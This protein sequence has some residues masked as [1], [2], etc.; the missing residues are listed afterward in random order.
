MPDISISPET[1]RGILVVFLY[2]LAVLAA[3]SIFNLAGAFGEILDQGLTG[4]FGW[5]RV[6]LPIVLAVFATKIL[7]PEKIQLRT[8]GSLGL[9]LLVLVSNGIIEIFTLQISP[10]DSPWYQGGG[11]LGLFFAAP[12]FSVMGF[13]AGTVVLLA[14]AVVALLLTFNT[15][16]HKIAGTTSIFAAPLRWFFNL[17]GSGGRAEPK[18][19]GLEAE[20]APGA[21]AEESFTSRAIEISVPKVDEALPTPVSA[22]P[23]TLVKRPRQR[24]EVPLDLL[25]LRSGKPAAGDI[26]ANIEKIRRTLERFGIPVEMSD[27]SVGPTVTQYTLRP[28]EGIKLS[29]IT[30]LSNDLALSLAAHPIRIEAPIPGKSLVGIEVPNSTVSLVPLREV[31]ESPEFKNRKNALEIALGKDV[32]GR[33]WTANIGK[34]PHLLVAGATGSGKSV[35]L[36]TIIVSLLYQNGPDDLRFIMV[37]PKRVELQVYNGVPHLITPVITDIAK[38]VNA[39][40]WTIGE[41][42]RRFDLLSKAGFRDIGS[43][44]AGSPEKLPYIVIVIDE[45]ADLMVAA[46]AEVES[47][48]I[49]L[50]QMARA[51]GIHLVLA[52]QRPSVDVI[53]GLIKANITTRIAFAVASGTDSRTILDSLGAEKL[54]GRGDLL[55]TTADLSKPKRLQGCLVTDEEIRKVVDHVKGTGGPPN[56]INEVTERAK[57]GP[58]SSTV[59]SQ[60]DSDPLLGEAEDTVLRAGKASASLLQRRLK[61]GYARAARLLDLLEEK[62]VI[63]PGD[64]AKP[65]EI[66]VSREGLD[67]LSGAGQGDEEEYDEREES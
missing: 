18:I 60:D 38:T 50:A 57:N 58:G 12:L 6:V 40:K 19:I 39:L 67:N 1:R 24:I 7:A 47:S 62:G 25:T 61:V 35:C 45:L 49:R 42:E 14:L 5:D 26:Q 65:R 43:Y 11:F 51:V 30:A 10:M 53:T 37:D 33:A 52:T 32:S 44:N 66:L 56:Y 59:F 17:F 2:A 22:E 27:V 20:E 29:R 9:V 23:E 36:N 54:L 15:S 8:T 21:E 4:L 55:Y 16:L 63:G 28:A 64:G 34:M 48:I 13:Y 31:L 41:M 3:L 46:A